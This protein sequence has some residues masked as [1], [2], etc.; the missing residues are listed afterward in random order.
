MR[1]LFKIVKIS[2]VFLGAFI[3]GYV[4]ARIKNDAIAHEYDDHEK[5]HRMRYGIKKNWE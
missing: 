3:L 5:D 4:R 1:L 2:L